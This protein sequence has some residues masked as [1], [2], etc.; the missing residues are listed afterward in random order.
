MLEDNEFHAILAEGDEGKVP[1]GKAVL[2]LGDHEPG[3]NA[4]VL[5][6]SGDVTGIVSVENGELRIENYDYIYNL[7]GQR[8]GKD[9]KGVVVV[10]GKKVVVK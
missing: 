8:V 2:H 5:K 1:A 4:K 6:I 3:A 9:Y 10:N 7:S